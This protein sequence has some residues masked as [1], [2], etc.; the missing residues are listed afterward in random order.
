M[1]PANRISTTKLSDLI[2]DPIVR[3]AFQRAERDYGQAFAVP[4]DRPQ[5]LNGGAAERV[6]ELEVA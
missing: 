6:R 4:T 1:A 5:V 3:A 2:R